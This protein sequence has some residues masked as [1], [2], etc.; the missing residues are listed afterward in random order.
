ML[1][2]KISELMN[3]KILENCV[4]TPDGMVHFLRVLPPNL[5]I[6]TDDEKALEPEK[7]ETLLNSINTP[8]QIFVMDKIEDMSLNKAFY[9]SL[10]PNF[11]WITDQMVSSMDK[12]ESS[13]SA[14]QRAYYFVTIT[15]NLDEFELFHTAV[16][17]RGFEV[18]PAERQE[19]ITVL[20]NFILREFVNFDLY[21]FSEEID[22]KYQA[23]INKKSLLPKSA[24][25]KEQLFQDEL[26]RRLLPQRIQFSSNHMVQNDFYRKVILIKNF[27]ST[28]SGDCF[29]SGIAQMKNTSLSIRLEQMNPSQ[30]KKLIDNQMN[31]VTA[32]GYGRRA[33]QQIE[34]EVEGDS[35]RTFYNNL[36]R[37]NS[38]IYLINIYIE[39]YAS[40]LEELKKRQEEICGRL[41]AFRITTEALTYEQKEGWRGIFPLSK[42]Q[43]KGSS[44]NM[45]TPTIGGM[46]PFSHSS[47]NDPEGM[48][49]GAT[50][51][52]GH[53]CLDFWVR[54]KSITNGNF[55]ITGESGQ[56]KSFLLNK[57]LYQQKIRGVVC[58][59]FDPE[60]ERCDMIHTLGG[61]N[62]NCAGGAVI[63]NPLQLRQLSDKSIENEESDL[64]AFNNKSVFFQHLSW[65]KDFFKVLFPEISAKEL[66]AL[67]IMTQG[68]YYRH[69]I[70]ENTDIRKLQPRDYP[71]FTDL[72]LYVKGVL[73]SPDKYEYPMISEE[74]IKAL[75][76]YLQDCHDGSLG[77]LLNGHTNIKNDQ[78]INFNLL[79]LLSGSNDRTQA[80][81]FN[82]L[83]YCWTRITL[84]EQ[85]ILLFVD[86]L[87]LLMKSK[88]LI[89]LEYLR[90]FEKRARKYDAS[91]G[92]ATQ[93]LGDFLD[94][95]I[96][97]TA[98]P[99]FN[100]PIFK[101]IFYPGM[102][103][104]QKVKDLLQLSDGE[105]A[106]IRT[107]RRGRCLLKAGSDKYLLQVGAL[108]FEADLF[109][110][111]GGR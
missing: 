31:N 107:P 80:V 95:A 105:L 100:T 79:E 65:L 62:I 93:Q 9:N 14:V 86:E 27:P 44:N 96:Y 34:A 102:L 40:S 72:Y 78:L 89:V 16:T 13:S 61:T 4:A 30:A 24:P 2:M 52:G 6:M 59:S 103:D 68:M 1:P 41:A 19:L 51:D 83:T 109:G 90:D 73:E 35:I 75:L 92:T 20:R 63:I 94:P 48:L 5:S 88:N 64:E 101:F 84:K 70:T 71:I 111:G 108:P 106:S 42:D 26:T 60:G 53:M 82:I 50:S 58:F 99:L 12:I 56:G 23:A 36:Q 33:T 45:P 18:Y 85:Y 55:V 25:D 66:A 46:Y 81:L 57:I 17:S 87:S 91:I 67:M 10:D 77:F 3:F 76:L 69:G 29:L 15:K 32:K 74:L 54:S 11:K 21:N 7:L 37:N 38:K 98:S 104:Y 97:Y 49:L 28:I 39:F 47:R 110:S 22:G 8:F 43:L